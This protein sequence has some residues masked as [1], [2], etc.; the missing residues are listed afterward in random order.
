M[1]SIVQKQKSEKRRL[2]KTVMNRKPPNLL[3]KVMHQPH[4]QIPPRNV[5]AA[6]DV[7]LIPMV[8]GHPAPCLI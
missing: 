7:M 8:R 2:R 4:S 6:P 3:K 1:M 5:V